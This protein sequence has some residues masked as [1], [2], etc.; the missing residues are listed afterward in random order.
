MHV[1][2]RRTHDV[3]ANWKL[4][5]EAFQE[6]YHIAVL[7]AG[8]VA[9]MFGH[10]ISRH[11]AMGDHARIA[12]A[13]RDFSGD[14]T[15]LSLSEAQRKVTFAYLIFPATIVIVSPTYINVLVSHPRSPHRTLVEN[16]MLIPSPPA[17]AEEAVHWQRSWDLLDISVY[18]REDFHA[19][20]LQ[21]QGL[22]PGM[23]ERVCIGD[24]ELPIAHFH[25]AMERHLS[26][27][28]P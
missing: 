18:E 27:T 9:K 3:Q 1:F 17:N 16:Y 8:S 10:S 21:Q 4:I 24:L 22:C 23:L 2:A 12:I 14:D 25:A 20:Q 5:V 15:L 11:S 6:T 19:T 7:H 13:R 28:S 26:S